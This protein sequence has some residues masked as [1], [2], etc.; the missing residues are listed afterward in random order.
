MDIELNPNLDLQQLQQTF[1][2]SGRLQV[3]DFLTTDSANYLFRLL[4][5]HQ[6]W[7]LTYNDGDQHFE[8]ERSEFMQLAPDAQQRFM[9]GIFGRARNGFQYLFN[10]Y[11]ITQALDLGEE[12]GHPMHQW[13]TFMNRDSTLE[14]LRM[15]TGCAEVQQADAYASWYEPLHF[16]NQHDDQHASHN[17]AAALVLNMTPVWDPNWG[18]QLAFFDQ[19]GN[20][21]QAFMPSFNNL[22]IF[23]VPQNHAVLQVAPFAGARRTSYLSWLLR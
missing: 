12:P 19:H 14:F 22:S 3:P 6:I 1:A 23:R 7:R 8:S 16:L 11:Y 10:Q 4:E 15:L 13:H 9:N 5:D 21:E 2:Q 18:G 17:R 20:V